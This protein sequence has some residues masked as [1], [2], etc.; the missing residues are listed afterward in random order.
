MTLPTHHK[1]VLAGAAALALAMLA[2][3]PAS[4]QNDAAAFY[5]GKQIRLVVGSAAGSG[6][7]LNARLVARYLSNHIPG[8]PSI[9]VQNQ[10]G[11]A[12]IVMV[13]ALANTAARDGTVM[14][15]PINGAITAPLLEPSAAHFDPL[16]LGWIGSSNRDTQ[17]CYVW[18]TSPIQKL[19]DLQTTEIV[20]G[21]TN[22]GTTQ[23][24]YPQVAAK[25][26]G[27]K[28]KIVSGYKGTTDIHL[29]MERGEVQGMGSNGWLSLKALKSDWVADKKVR[30]ITVF[31]ENPDPELKGVPSIFTLAKTEADKQALRLMVARL[32]YGRPF[33][34]PP[35]VPTYLLTAMR[36]AFD[37]T[38]NDPAF[39]AEAAKVNIDIDA[40]SGQKVEEIIT[41]VLKTPPDV[42]KRVADALANK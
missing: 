23:V 32:E 14:G 24:D 9:I 30:L 1:T 18:H 25:I 34:F 35:G 42:V 39:I 21:A 27:L 15:A 28:F 31:N 19:S 37:E 40:I 17:V 26:L 3:P 22:P 33:F 16:K 38:M 2:S 36:K 7:D 11:A 6:Y 4:A 29:A 5:R 8:N 41:Q 12:S 13:N 10:P 20:V